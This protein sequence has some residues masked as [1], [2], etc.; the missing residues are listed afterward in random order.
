[1]NVLTSK[2]ND[3]KQQFYGRN[4]MKDIIKYQK[5]IVNKFFQPIPEDSDKS[6]TIYKTTCQCIAFI[7]RFLDGIAIFMT[8]LSTKNIVITPDET[9]KLHEQSKDYWNR[10][11]YI[12][13]YSESLQIFDGYTY[14]YANQT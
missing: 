7:N 6:V 14:R 3:D 2:I 9:E 10:I 8:L 12:T 5:F 11:C 1:M 13:K 4:V